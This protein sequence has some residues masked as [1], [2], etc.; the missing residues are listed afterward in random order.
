M[1]EDTTQTIPAPDPAPEPGG[2]PPLRRT[3]DDK[4][5]GGVCA[6]IARHLGVDP[7][8]VRLAVVALVVLGG[9][10]LLL[11]PLA[12][13]FIKGEPGAPGFGRAAWI[14]ALVVAAFVVC[15]GAFVVGALT[16]GFG[17]GVALGIVLVVVAIA[18]A[19]LSVPSRRARWAVAPALALAL[20]GAIPAAADIDLRGGFGSDHRAPADATTLAS[21]VQR[22]GAGDAVYDLR[23]TRF[24]RGDTRVHLRVGAGRL[25]VLVPHGVCVSLDAHAGLGRVVAFGRQAGG[26]D[27]DVQADPVGAR[28]V[29]RLVLSAKLG[30]GTVE[31]GDS[32]R[33]IDALDESGRG[34]SVFAPDGGNGSLGDAVDRHCTAA[35]AG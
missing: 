34:R 18:I 16:V 5:I 8:L 26:A 33:Q 3:A 24:E 13:I 15:G 10:S 7:V 21:G 22:L 19:A 27:V 2:R 35:R 4:L 9:F 31:I 12:W 29:P 17:G 20:G 30:A 14:A 11:Y 25:R 6:G 23:Q 28:R 32:A 1:N